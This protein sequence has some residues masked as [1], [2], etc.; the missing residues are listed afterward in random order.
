M[1]K[2][3]SPLHFSQKIEK[4][5]YEVDYILLTVPQTPLGMQN[6]TMTY[7]QVAQLQLQMSNSKLP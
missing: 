2:R 7:L 4:N 3:T 5:K 6:N 1:H